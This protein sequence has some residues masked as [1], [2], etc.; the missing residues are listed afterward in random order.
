MTATPKTPMSSV[1]SK[2]PSV[3]NGDHKYLFFR[4][5]SGTLKVSLQKGVT[6]VLREGYV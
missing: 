1:P 5:L 2:D 4:G 3:S 6:Y